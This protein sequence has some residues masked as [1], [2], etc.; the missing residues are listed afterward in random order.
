[1]QKYGRTTRLTK[2]RVTAI[3]VASIVIYTTGPRLFT[4]QIAIELPRKTKGTFSASGD[5]GSLVV[6]DPGANPVGLLFAGSDEVTLANPIQ[7]VLDAF[8]VTVDGA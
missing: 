8:S 5:S 3:N 2:G 6:T 1:M 7:K 4:G